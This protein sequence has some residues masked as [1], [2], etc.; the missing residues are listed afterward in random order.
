MAFVV[1]TN[2]I[3]TLDEIEQISA[4]SKLK[5]GVLIP[6]S[7]NDEIK[8]F[9]IDLQPVSSSISVVSVKDSETE[10]F[11]TELAIKLQKIALHFVI[12]LRASMPRIVTP[13]KWKCI[14]DVIVRDKDCASALQ[15]I[16]TNNLA[17]IN[18]IEKN[19]QTK[20]LG[21]ADV[22]V[23]TTVFGNRNHFALTM[24]TSI[25]SALYIT[26][27]R[28]KD[29]I[30]PIFG[31]LRLMFRDEPLVFIDALTMTIAKKRY[32]FAKNVA[33]AD[34]SRVCYED[35]V[36]SVDDVLQRKLSDLI[37]TANWSSRK[38]N[39]IQLIALREQVRNI[40][41]SNTKHNG[42]LS[43][44]EPQF[45]K[46]LTEVRKILSTIEQQTAT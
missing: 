1:D 13:T 9:K 39:Y 37:D 32:K 8:G 28:F 3:I 24:D 15:N 22:H 14:S 41:K 26:D 5:K 25:W 17:I 6:E 4:L 2:F 34:A 12:E 38:D 10:R 20:I 33:D 45:I 46:D 36:R 11:I 23:C 21:Y 40:V 7:V 29:R 19:T 35:L 18:V 31:S 27:P 42:E 43:F 16:I 30:I 44:D